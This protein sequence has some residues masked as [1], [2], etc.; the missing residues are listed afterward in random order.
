M[1]GLSFLFLNNGISYCFQSPGKCSFIYS[2][3]T[4]IMESSHCCKT[5]SVVGWDY[6]RFLISPN[7]T[8]LIVEKNSLLHL[9]YVLNPPSPNLKKENEN[10]F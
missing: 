5:R 1:L 8:Y 6:G 4:S 3:N 9:L 2:K 10:N 7:S